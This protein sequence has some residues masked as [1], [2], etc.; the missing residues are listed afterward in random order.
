MSEYRNEPTLEQAIKAVCS[1]MLSNIHTVL[2]GQIESYDRAKHKAKV[3]PLIK[4]VLVNG[5]I[6]Q[7]PPIVSV[8]VVWPRTQNGSISFPLSSGDGVIILFSERA[9]DNYLILGGD[10]QPQDP[11]K[12]DLTDAIA[13]PGLFPFNA[14][15][16]EESETDFELHFNN[17]K[18]VFK[19]NGDIE[20]TGG[21]TI[22]VKANG[23]IEIGSTALKALV[24]EDIITAM[25]AHTHGVSGAV[26]TVP[27][28]VPPLSAALHTT[29]KTKAQ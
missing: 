29:Q 25:S 12:F 1:N 28:Y 11:R 22:T 26:T 6:L 13:I 9:L 15:S 4:K 2:P 5:V 23:D 7:I 16:K 24:H 3:K 19:E 10:Q 18:M 20:L 17:T 14:S 8:P 27:T 21:N